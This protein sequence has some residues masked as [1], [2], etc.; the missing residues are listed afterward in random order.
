MVG[1]PVYEIRPVPDTRTA[2]IEFS[3]AG[4]VIVRIRNGARQ[5]VSDASE[6]VSTAIALRGGQRCPI[7]VDIRKAAPLAADVRRMYSGRNIADAFTALA[8][9]IDSS[10]LGRTMGNV[11]FSVARLPMPMK[12]F[13]EESKALEWLDGHRSADYFCAGGGAGAGVAFAG[14]GV[15]AGPGTGCANGDG[16]GPEGWVNGVRPPTTDP[17]PCLP[18][19]PNANAPMMK[20][21]AQIQVARDNTVAPLRA[22]NAAWLLAPPNALAMSPPFPC[23]RYTASIIAKQTRM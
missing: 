2:R 15:V 16:V 6:N 21:A 20:T 22:P 18:M 10:P 7:L 4:I 17:G 14:G 5:S 13:S 23:C 8:L 12:M 19:M 11:Y 3:D 9:L 1:H